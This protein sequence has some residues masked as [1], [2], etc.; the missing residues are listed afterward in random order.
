MNGA[1]AEHCEHGLGATD[2]ATPDNP[3][4]VKETQGAFL[5]AYAKCGNIQNAATANVIEDITSNKPL[6]PG[7]P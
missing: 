6:L 1:D 2:N 3:N 4:A 7:E 5:D